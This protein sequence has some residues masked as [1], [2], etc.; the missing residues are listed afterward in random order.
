MQW[1]RCEQNATFE[2]CS[3]TFS[4]SELSGENLAML[5]TKAVKMVIYLLT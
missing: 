4:T 3:V 5:M 2:S 1:L